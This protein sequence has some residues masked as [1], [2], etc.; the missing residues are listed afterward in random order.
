MARNNDIS[1][2]ISGENF[3]STVYAYENSGTTTTVNGDGNIVGSTTGDISGW[4]VGNT[5]NL[6]VSGGGRQ[7]WS[8]LSNEGYQRLAEYRFGRD[9]LAL[10]KPLAA[11]TRNGSEI[12]FTATDGTKLAVETTDSSDTNFMVDLGKVAAVKIGQT[13]EGNVFTY[14]ADTALFVG[15]VQFD[16]ISVNGD[17]ALDLN[18]Q[19][20][21]VEGVDA[22]QSQ[23]NVVARG[24]DLVDNVFASGLG[25]N[26]FFGGYYSNDT[27][28]SNMF[29][30]I[31]EV[32]WGAGGGSDQMVQSKETDRLNIAN[33]TLAEIAFAGQF[34]DNFAIALTTG[35]TFVMDG[36]KDRN[37]SVAGQ[38]FHYSAATASWSSQQVENG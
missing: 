26:T 21:N 32:V 33:V 20:E 15:G 35:E 25:Y 12:D 2:D 4:N 5:L 6:D 31:T 38:E 9:I 28:I 7:S 13:Y 34:G 10:D 23:G 16:A 36:N 30:G 3:Q 14:Q 29:G 19:T 24:S 22:S 27:Y 11:V 18:V 37:V 1:V 17:A 8:Q